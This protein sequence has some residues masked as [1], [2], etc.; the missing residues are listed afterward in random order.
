[1]VNALSLAVMTVCGGGRCVTDP[2]TLETHERAYA[3]ILD[4][5]SA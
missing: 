3:R 1:M 5:V 2:S 4:L